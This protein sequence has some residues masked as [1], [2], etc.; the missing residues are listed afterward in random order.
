M[1]RSILVTGG[2]GYVGSHVAFQL[3]AHGWDVVVVDN[4]QTGHR[5][6][7]PERADFVELDLRDAA[8]VEGVFR[9]GSF[10]AVMHFAARSLVGESTEQPLEYLSDNVTSALNL[11]RSAAEHGVRRFVLSSTANLFGQAG[12]EPITE[13]DPIVP[14]SPYGESKHIIERVLDWADRLCGLRYAALRYFNAAGAHPNGTLGE[15]HEPETHLIPIVL[16]VAL[17]KRPHVVIFGEDYPTPDGTCIRDYVHVLDLADAH[18]RALDVIETESVTLNLGTGTGY[19]VREVIE[20]AREVTGAEIPA[21]A[22]AR[23]QG[24]P[25]V[26][27]ASAERAR[28]RLMWTPRYGDLRSIIETAWAWHRAHP[29]GYATPDVKAR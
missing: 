5:S 3:I 22:G 27:V 12:S 11:I 28:E 8:A 10:G 25:A 7:V 15:H 21:L 29:D 20:V 23:R 16:E 6:A 24:D 13:D 4:L 14:G 17:G 9:G 19:S 18:I 1:D 26:L 2:A